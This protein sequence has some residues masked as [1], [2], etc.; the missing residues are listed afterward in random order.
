[1]KGKYVCENRGNYGEM[2]VFNTIIQ[3]LHVFFSDL[4]FHYFSI[5]LL[6]PFYKTYCRWLPNFIS[7]KKKM[8]N[9]SMQK[10]VL[11]EMLDF[12]IIRYVI[13]V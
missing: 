7:L 2:N 9:L 12:N 1:M 5:I 6:A 10:H 13:F 8:L 4:R 11:K 3:F